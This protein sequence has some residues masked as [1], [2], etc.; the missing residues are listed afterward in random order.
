MKKEQIIHV[1][2]EQQQMIL[3][4]KKSLYEMLKMLHCLEDETRQ[5][6][7]ETSRGQIDD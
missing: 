3:S 7:I 2:I 1:M 6:E 4:L 5:L